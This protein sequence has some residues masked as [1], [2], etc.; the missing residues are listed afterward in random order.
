M[1]KYEKFI[2]ASE[3]KLAEALSWVEKLAILRGKP[4][5]ADIY[6]KMLEF[7]YEKN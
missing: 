3:E 1:T 7:E 6:K 5:G 2:T 4:L